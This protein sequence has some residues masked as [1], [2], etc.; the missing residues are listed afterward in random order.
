MDQNR[1]NPNYSG[2]G[3]NGFTT[4]QSGAYLSGSTVNL[5]SNGGFIGMNQNAQVEVSGSTISL[6]GATGY[7]AFN[8]NQVDGNYHRMNISGGA[9]HS[10][11]STY[12]VG[13]D[14]INISGA[15]G[16]NI[17]GLASYTEDY[18]G[19][20]GTNSLV[21]K[22]YVDSLD[23]AQITGVSA[24]N[25]IIGGGTAGDV[26]LN[27]GG[28]VSS[29]ITFD[30]N[31]G[32]ASLNLGNFGPN[33]QMKDF[34][35][36][37]ENL[38][39]FQVQPDWNG[40]G[41]TS[42]PYGFLTMGD[43]GNGVPRTSL[44]NSPVEGM[45]SLFAFTASMLGT[46]VDV[47]AGGPQANLKLSSD[48]ELEIEGSSMSITGSSMSITSEAY[49]LGQTGAS[50]SYGSMYVSPGETSSRFSIGTQSGINF[51]NS[52]YVAGNPNGQSNLSLEIGTQSLSFSGYNLFNQNSGNIVGADLFVGASESSLSYSNGYDK[53]ELTLG[54]SGSSFVAGSMSIQSDSYTFGP[55]GGSFS[56]SSNSDYLVNI[57][58]D[59]TI[60][61]SQS[62]LS[63]SSYD[64]N[65]SLSR[66]A[67]LTISATGSYLYGGTN[68]EFGSLTLGGSGSSFVAGS[69]SI[70]S[71]NFNLGQTGASFSFG[72]NN[73]QPGQSGVG[74][75][76]GTQ[77]GINLTN[78]YYPPSSAYGPGYNS[79]TIGSQSVS[80]T[81]GY[82]DNSTGAFLKKGL[83]IGTASTLSGGT[84][85]IVVGG[86]GASGPISI[87]GLASYTEDYSAQFGTH[88][89]VTK[90]YVDSLDAAQITGVSA[91]NGLLGGGTAG[92]VTLNLGGTV[93]SDIVFSFTASTS[94]N[95]NNSSF[96][97][98][99][100]ETIGFF[101]Q[102]TS[103]FAV[104]V[105]EVS[106]SGRYGNST[107]SI[108]LN[109]GAYI[110]SGHTIGLDAGTVSVTG[111]DKVAISGPSNSQLLMST[112]GHML[113]S[114]PEGSILV[115]SA[116]GDVALTT[117]SGDAR[118][119]TATGDATL[120]SG[121]NTL[122]LGTS[123]NTFTD[124]VNTKGIEYAAD[125]SVNFTDRSLVDKAYA[126]T[127]VSG[128][129][130]G[131]GLSGGGAD[132][133]ITLN[134]D[135]TIDG[136][137]TFSSTGDA[138]TIEVV[139]DNT[140]IQVVDGALAVVA[141]T[142]QPVYQSATSSVT[143]GDTGITLTSTPNDYSRI[144]VYV[145]GQLQNLTENTTGDCYFGAAGT[146]LTSLTSG[147][148][149]Y[150]NS[151]NAGFELSATD[152]I[153]VH[154]QA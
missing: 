122:V 69:M 126:D 55:S 87:T 137:L 23:A 144:E 61:G 44:G 19:Q 84:A 154:Y 127:K 98:Q 13:A 134:A 74:F 51:T 113:M 54:G 26:T 70:V 102:Q 123:S 2:S 27:L 21:T 110:T 50:F 92:D 10:F 59:F 148:S 1:N 91:G 35:A 83:E 88:S 41:L 86:T 128:V 111:T 5:Q 64:T 65:I 18:S 112:D 95:N 118:V 106:V 104:D 58:N 119:T 103:V 7:S 143:N 124:G 4:T 75:D 37:Y 40:S 6:Q 142:S 33:K 101:G 72:L 120:G 147:D 140:T 151:A 132:G 149:L 121:T 67:G 152:V 115:T 153:K 47:S 3:Y 125:Y 66:T 99:N 63:Y 16:I 73:L 43:N 116:L 11:G 31:N 52:H 39:F 136:G 89:L 85:S 79:L 139:V 105:K 76:L 15:S 96:I 8:Y 14:V 49:T 36:A 56:Y 80:L 93:S 107:S 29:D 60:N 97:L 150:W 20:F 57:S 53:S 138:G 81:R 131:A 30:F 25:G 146:V 109:Q 17:T 71:N 130:A 24:G 100:A 77:S 38:T 94:N 129:T 12:S 68:E 45:L 141:G 133:D 28:T 9:S 62:S 135:L 78:S 42:P 145:N 108:N 32:T 117:A 82:Y 90:A 114:T 48:N 34:T 46:D 22:A